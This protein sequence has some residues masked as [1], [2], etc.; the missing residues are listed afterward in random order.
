M[1]HQMLPEAEH[2]DKPRDAR[3]RIAVEN[4]RDYVDQIAAR[5]HVRNRMPDCSGG[6][7]LS[8]KI[9][10]GAAVRVAAHPMRK[11]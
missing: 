5:D 2:G 9:A 3:V 8:C 10:G 1:V 11:G 7:I 4:T 6:A